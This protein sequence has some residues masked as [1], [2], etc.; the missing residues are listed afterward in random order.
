MGPDP[1]DPATAES[2]GRAMADYTPFLD[3]ASLQGARLGVVRN[4]GGYHERVDVVFEAALLALRKLGATL[5]DPT[6][7]PTLGEI[8]EPEFEV[9]LTEFKDG[10]ERYLAGTGPAVTA[11]TLDDLIAFNRSAADRE[12][13]YFGQERFLKAAEKQGLADPTYTAAL[14]RCRQLARDEGIDALLAEHELDALIAPTTGPAWTVDL[15]NGDRYLGSASTPA[16][17]AGYP[18]ITVPMG[19]IHGLP[20][21][22]SFF[23]GAYAEP[24]LLRLA[25][26]FE[27]GTGWRRLPAFLP[28][29]SEE[30]R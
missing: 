24:I 19:Y 8:G 15:L 11:R 30:G 13:V 7:I 2:A 20:V 12:L 10:V 6:D 23:A 26:A 1:R 27:Q 4:L 17:V 21:G 25:Y 16:A 3:P 22:L 5:I 18:H 29:L 9:L 14:A 28:Q